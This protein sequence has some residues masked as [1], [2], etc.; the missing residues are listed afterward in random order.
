[1]LAA[2][3][4]SLLVT[5]AVVGFNGWPDV[6]GVSLAP[7]SLVVSSP[8]P[9]K[10]GSSARA[11]AAAGAVPTLALP[12]PRRAAT[13]RVSVPA[14]HRTTTTGGTAS[15]SSPS[16]GGRGTT[17][18]SSNTGNTTSGGQSPQA[19]TPADSVRQV[20]G[21]VGDALS[22]ATNAAGGAVDHVVPG[23]GKVVQGAGQAV[24]GGTDGPPGHKP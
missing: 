7:A 18:N 21:A 1:M 13:R 16:R 8:G 2:I 9:A 11:P 14:V 5:S 24:G 15:T 4:C 19:A 12:A 17:S 23:A 10:S 20:T 6:P 22:G 3:A